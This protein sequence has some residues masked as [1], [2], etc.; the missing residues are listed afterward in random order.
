MRA[1]SLALLGASLLRKLAAAATVSVDRSV[2]AC[3]SARARVRVDE[4]GLYSPGRHVV[5]FFLLL[6]FPPQQ[7]SVHRR[8][9]PTSARRKAGAPVARTTQGAAGIFDGGA[10]A[11]L[12]ADDLQWPGERRHRQGGNCQ[13]WTHGEVCSAGGGQL[14]GFCES[15]G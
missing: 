12:P 3:Y 7:G 11:L 14:R 10:T 13:L 1:L 4:G 5:V 9:L 6:L 2:P 8:R 15:C